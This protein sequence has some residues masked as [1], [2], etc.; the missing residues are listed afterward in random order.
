MNVSRPRLVLFG[1]DSDFSRGVF[2]KLLGRIDLEVSALVLPAPAPRGF[3]VLRIQGRRCIADDAMRAGVPVWFLHHDDELIER[4]DDLGAQY[5]LLACFPRKLSPRLAAIARRDCLNLHPSLLPRYRGPD[6][7][8]W[9]LRDGACETGVTLHHVEPCIDAGTIVA[10]RHVALAAG[11]TRAEIEAVLADAGAELFLSA[12]AKS[13]DQRPV[14]QDERYASYHPLP[15]LSDYRIPASWPVS[16]AFNFLR[17]AAPAGR[18]FEITEA[19]Q[20][21]RVRGVQ[22]AWRELRNEWIIEGDGWVEVRFSD[23]VIRASRA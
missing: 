13:R 22:D 4:L 5:L 18:V 8:F 12:V 9:Q 15:T 14:A 11:A 6:P 19:E 17:G 7:L 23:G 2:T 10:T 20:S 3:P 21:I 1:M 16:R